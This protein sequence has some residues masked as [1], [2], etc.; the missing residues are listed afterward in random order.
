MRYYPQVYTT[1][2]T[3][4]RQ[5]SSTQINGKYQRSHAEM[6][7]N[8]HE[9]ENNAPKASRMSWVPA[10]RAGKRA[11]SAELDQR[12]R[13]DLKQFQTA[14][15][16]RSEREHVGADIAHITHTTKR[17]PRVRKS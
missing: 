15:A 11:E 8:M 3:L 12:N 10:S 13:R 17:A 6:H 1:A 9:S 2:D 16:L 7:I 5:H 14:E 4:R